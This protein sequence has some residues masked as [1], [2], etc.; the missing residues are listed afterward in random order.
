MSV[1]RRTSS[2]F[3]WLS[4]LI[5]TSV[6][7]WWIITAKPPESK[8]HHA[9]SAADL[10]KVNETE[11]GV[12][13]LTEEAE[14]RLGVQ[15]A[16]VER[17]NINR[18]RIYGGEVMVPA[19]KTILVSAPMQGTLQ[20]PKGGVPQAG[21]AV[22][23]GQHVFSLLPLFSAEASTTLA[24]SR[25]DVEGQVKNAQTQLAAMKLALDR[26]QRLFREEAG[27]KR[28]VE[29]AQAQHDL[30]ARSLEAAESRLAILTKA[31]GNAATG[32]AEPIH[33]ESPESGILR[34]VSALPGQNVPSGGALFEVIDLSEIWVRVPV[35]VGD[36]REIAAAENAQIG[37]LSMQS[38]DPTWPAI[39]VQA[40]PSANPLSATVD[41]FYSLQNDAAQLTPGQRVGVKLPLSTSGESLTVP[42]SSVLHDLQGG[43]WVYEVL[44]PRTYRRQRVFVR[45]AVDD[46]AVLVAGPEPGTNVVSEGAVEIFGAETGFSK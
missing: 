8:P 19:G 29:E 18:V 26:A 7:A 20:A 34:N 33:L 5:A 46:T 36:L 13:T 15:A 6:G 45:Y 24:T 43:T 32:R 21:H 22:T 14:Q 44:G 17:K 31:V 2:I 23:K 40:P 25:A 41:L 9:A 10:K 42:W 28:N 38:G 37:N 39:P 1:L 3:A 11:L 35:Y 30:A 27:S 12:I 16:P 4:V